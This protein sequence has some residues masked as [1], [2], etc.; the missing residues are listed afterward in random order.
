VHEDDLNREGG[1][2]RRSDIPGSFEFRLLRLEKQDDDKEVRM[3]RVETQNTVID[4]KLTTIADNIAEANGSIK[5]MQR[6]QE[7]DRGSTLD[8]YRKT[9]WGFA[10][11]MAG[12]IA[13][14]IAA[15]FWTVQA[16]TA[17]VQHR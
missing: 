17:T 1:S 5:E 4:T 8:L 12:A 2:R 6:Q 10:I 15:H 9:I 16:V 13:T 14:A 7:R 3:R 11:A